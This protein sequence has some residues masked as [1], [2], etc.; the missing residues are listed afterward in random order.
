[1]DTQIKINFISYQNGYGLSKDMKLLD[2]KL[3]LL[4]NKDYQLDIKYCDYYD[5]TIRNCDINIFFETISNIQL[6]KA[7]YNIL[8]PNQEWFYQSWIDYLSNIDLILCKTQYATDIFKRYHKNV[9]YISWESEDLYNDKIEKDYN[10]IIHIC[11]KSTLKQTDRILDLWKDKYPELLV[12]Y[13]PNKIDYQEKYK[14]KTNIRFINKKVD[15]DEFIKLINKYGIHICCSETEGYGHYIQESKGCKNIVISTNGGSMKELI[16]N[17]NFLVDV[18]KKEKIKDVLDYKYIIDEKSFD[19]KLNN[20]LNLSNIE[21]QKIGENNRNDY[22]ISQ[23]NFSDNLKN[24]MCNIFIKFSNDKITINNIKERVIDND[25]L[26][27]ISIVTITYNR[28]QFIKLLLLNFYQT[29][30]PK[31]KIEWIIIDDSDTDILKDKIPKNDN[32][33]HYYYYE[34]RLKIGNKRNR[35]VEKSNYDY[36]LFM[37]DD[38]YYPPESF[39]VRI[40]NLL[41][42]NKQCLFCSS[43]GCFHINKYISIM[44]VPPHKLPFHQRVSEATLT[45]HKDFWR[46]TQFKEDSNGAEGEE[47]IKNRYHQCLEIEPEKIIVS[48]LHNKNTSHKD[49]VIDKPNGCHFGFSDKLFNFIT[50]LD[51][52]EKNRDYNNKKFIGY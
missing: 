38:D 33:I 47:F 24:I 31:D 39:K 5:H 28:P 12:I 49:L 32:R 29:N 6:K 10:K 50:N 48:L 35:G 34:T 40:E 19:I 7:K 27:K 1:M 14:N 42:Y 18:S 9:I 30:Y 26:P 37:D 46:E 16:T 52:S 2:T 25:N 44:N 17:T 4:F 20:I 45:F 21:K 36:I 51:N 15:N 11:G 41:K 13:K 3:K 8:I 22:L 43:I 23:Q